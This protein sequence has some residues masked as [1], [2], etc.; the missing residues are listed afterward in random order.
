[1]TDKKTSKLN[2][3]T[4]D[5]PFLIWERH[6]LTE[7]GN[8]DI[9]DKKVLAALYWEDLTDTQKSDFTDAEYIDLQKVKAAKHA[10]LV[11]DPVKMKKHF[12]EG[13][14]PLIDEMLSLANGQKKSKSAVKDTDNE[15]WAKRE[16]WSVL[17]DIIRTTDN[18]APM[19]DLKGGTIDEQINTILEKV[20]AGQI[21]IADAKEYMALV[22]AGFNLQ[23]LPK[24]MKSLEALEK[25]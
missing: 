3:E 2:F 9:S 18:P 17:K 24:L 12:L 10:E 11:S 20:S 8:L 7:W 13:A 4:N 5:K 16:I 6:W 14:A 22:S 25:K 15:A 1:M 21:T 19:L 23:Q